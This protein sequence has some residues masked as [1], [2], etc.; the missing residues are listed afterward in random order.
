MPGL[1]PSRSHDFWDY[2]TFNLASTCSAKQ[3]S[4]VALDGARNVIEYVSTLSSFLGILMHDSVNS[5][6]QGKC[7]VAV[8]SG[9]G[10]KFW[11]STHTSDAASALS[12]GQARAITRNSGGNADACPRSFLSQLHTSVWS[13]VAIISGPY[14]S[15]TSRVECTFNWANAVLGSTSSTSII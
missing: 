7:V 3:G 8:P 15:T 1:V 9:P 10:A 11:A 14:D 12:V 6:P 2:Q 13:Q 5:F 4:L